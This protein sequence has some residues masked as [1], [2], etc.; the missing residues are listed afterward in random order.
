MFP[1]ESPGQFDHSESKTC[2]SYGIMCTE[3]NLKLTYDL[4]RRTLPKERSLDYEDLI[5]R[6]AEL[7]EVLKDEV[8]FV[9]LY[10]DFCLDLLDVMKK[11]DPQGLSKVYDSPSIFDGVVGI[12]LRELRK[13]PVRNF[14]LYQPTRKKIMNEFTDMLEDLFESEETQLK[15]LKD[16]IEMKRILEITL[17]K[18]DMG[19]LAE[20]S[21]LNHESKKYKIYLQGHQKY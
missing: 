16:V 15:E 20:F 11:R 9:Q 6:S 14:I 12:L 1:R 18:E 19:H 4:A 13:K 10:Q 8:V 17:N 3:E 21:E 5:K 7:K 2:G